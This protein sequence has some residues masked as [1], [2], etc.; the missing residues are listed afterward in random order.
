M[1]GETETLPGP[2]PCVV[3]H[4]FVVVNG[5]RLHYV[6]AGAGP[7]VILLHGFPESAGHISPICGRR[8]ITPP[9][10]T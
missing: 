2:P 6:E 5:V 8:W 4:R 1:E 3:R 9:R 10:R 7:A